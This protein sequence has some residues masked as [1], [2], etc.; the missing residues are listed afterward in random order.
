MLAAFRKNSPH[1][2]NPKKNIDKEHHQ[3]MS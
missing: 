3:I 1:P 2:E